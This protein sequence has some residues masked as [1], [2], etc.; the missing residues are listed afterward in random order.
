VEITVGKK[1]N[2]ILGPLRRHFAKPEM[3]QLAE[4]VASFEV[5]RLT[6]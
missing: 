3:K 1:I 5:T 6:F 4:L 2:E